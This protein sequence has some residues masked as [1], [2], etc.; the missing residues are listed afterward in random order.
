MST[1]T[2][3]RVR[4]IDSALLP[5]PFHFDRQGRLVIATSGKRIAFPV[6]ELSDPRLSTIEKVIKGR[7]P[8]VILAPHLSAKARE[9]IEDAEWGWLETRGNAHIDSRGIY[10]HI[11]SPA[12]RVV[13]RPGALLIPPQG[14]RIARYLLD[15]FPSAHTFTE[16]AGFTKLDK[17]YTSRILSRLRQ[18]G[19]VSYSR[20]RPVEVSDPAELFEL[21]Q[22][23][24]T[25][26]A[27]S[28]WFI[29]Q[30]SSVQLLAASV[31]EQAGRGRAAFTGVFAANLLAPHLEPER[32]ECYVEDA[33]TAS[34]IAEGLGGTP[35][36][37]GA[38]LVFL[39]HRDPGILTIGART[40]GR[41]PVV[42]GTQIYRDALRLGRGREREAAN[43]LR[44]GI[45][46]W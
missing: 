11:E 22:A 20:N 23:G 16:I 14:E 1:M 46:T 28:H 26:T 8:H 36:S 39:I 6:V 44:R 7:R 18:R 25:R 24:P 32:V 4:D 5:T 3:P 38:N 13:R 40:V 37:S 34:R 27:E 41:L 10:I 2:K 35:T 21:W 17:G 31:H 30:P 29:E 45:L 42:S 9:A 19:L 33:R 12:D 43:H 15:T